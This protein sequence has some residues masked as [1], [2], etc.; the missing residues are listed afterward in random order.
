MTREEFLDDLAYEYIE[1]RERGEVMDLS[2]YDFTPDEL[3]ALKESCEGYQI[4]EKLFAAF[5][6]EWFDRWVEERVSSKAD[7]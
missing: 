1:R 7:G 3:E 2:E 6:K 4:A 5:P